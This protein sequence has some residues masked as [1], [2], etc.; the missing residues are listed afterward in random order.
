MEISLSAITIRESGADD[1]ASIMDVEKQ[2]FGYEKEAALVAELLQDASALPLLSLL[3]FDGD[4][5]IGHILFTRARFRGQE[6]P[7]LM[8]ILA[9]L[10][11]RPEY[12]KKG[13]GGQLI[14]TGLDLL[15]QRGSVLVFVLG[16]KEYYPRFG[17]QPYAARLGFPPPYPMPEENAGYWMVQSLSPNGLSGSRGTINCAD[18][19][20]KPQHWRDDEND[21][22]GEYP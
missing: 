9:P 2:A 21:Q 11:V 8:H 3:A 22:R 18:T 12:Q 10:A 15:R 6:S 17:F 7:P 20:D 14:K 1:F 5:A 13:V 4:V 19:L 16:H